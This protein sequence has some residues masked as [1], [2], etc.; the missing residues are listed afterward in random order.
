MKIFKRKYYLI[1]TKRVSTAYHN[2]MKGKSNFAVTV[3]YRKKNKEGK[4][5]FYIDYDIKDKHLVT[6]WQAKW[7]MFLI[8]VFGKSN[9]KL[10]A[11]KLP[12]G[13][14]FMKKAD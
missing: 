5:K 3:L 12:N 7:W 14:V 2:G 6:W 13:T 1:Y 4:T 11:Y 8:R 9:K 10:F